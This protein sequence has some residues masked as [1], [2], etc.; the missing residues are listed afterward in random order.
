MTIL[1]SLA[2]FLSYQTHV[3]SKDIALLV[4][5]TIPT[6]SV[7]VGVGYI[8][9]VKGNFFLFQVDYILKQ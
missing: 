1:T 2:W 7:Y 6:L 4:K 5:S 8:S 3:N 9:A